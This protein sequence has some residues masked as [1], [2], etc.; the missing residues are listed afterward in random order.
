MILIVI[1]VL[2]SI[3]GILL[4]TIN[5]K[6]RP[7]YQLSDGRVVPGI[8]LTVVGGVFLFIFLI[9]IPLQH[10]EIKARIEQFKAVRTT[11]DIARTEGREIESAALVLEIAK[12][13]A[14]LVRQQYW[15]NHYFGIYYPDE[16][17]R[18][19]PLK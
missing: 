11:I 19:Q 1:A 9:G 14:W 3:V 10:I 8:F 7:L 4:F 18:L 17:M 15:N 12:R 2:M 16:I 5:K 6:G 13:N